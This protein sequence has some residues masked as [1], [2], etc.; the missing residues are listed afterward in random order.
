MRQYGYTIYK[1]SGGPWFPAE[2]GGSTRRNDTTF[3]HITDTSIK[4]LTL[5][6]AGNRITKVKCIT[7]GSVGYKQDNND[8]NL[9]L[10]HADRS[11]NHIIIQIRFKKPVTGMI[12]KP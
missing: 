9:D 5:P 10:T 7:G 3:V 12:K 6:S 11:N 1:T 2:W 4:S 8:L